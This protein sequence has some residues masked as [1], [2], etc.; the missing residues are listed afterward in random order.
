MKKEHIKRRK[1]VMPASSSAQT[2]PHATHES[3]VS[4]D[5][6]S[7]VADQM[8]AGSRDEYTPNQQLNLPHH[9]R[10]NGAGVG[11]QQLPPVRT[12]AQRL[13]EPPIHSYG[14]PPVDFTHY[15]SAP[16]LPLPR[17]YNE[18]PPIKSLAPH[19]N[20]STN[21]RKRTL[22][23]TAGER[24]APASSAAN[25][26]NDSIDPNLSVYARRAESQVDAMSGT[27]SGES[28]EQRMERIRR[29]RDRLA[30]QVVAMNR[31]LQEMEEE[32][33]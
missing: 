1:R 26:S 17:P 12:A 20:A 4:P 19:A 10:P 21:T 9:D 16:I 14:P 29:E 25:N 30:E 13:M 3:S 15:T 11:G 33:G 7:G 23:E 24:P 2:P 8:G 31:Q 28:R 22:S 6:Q 27:G 5:P 32:A 18:L